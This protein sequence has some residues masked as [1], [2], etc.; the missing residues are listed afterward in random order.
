MLTFFLLLLLVIREADRTTPLQGLLL[1][2]E[3][4]DE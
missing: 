2:F 3:I 1:A 4:D